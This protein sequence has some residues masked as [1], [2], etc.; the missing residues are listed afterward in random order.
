MQKKL[1]LT[2]DERVYDGL[3]R[4]IGRGSISQFIEALVRPYVID[5]D[6]DAA[7][8]EMAADQAREAEAEEWIEA[9][10]GDGVIELG[11][12]RRQI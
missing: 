10:V 8:R 3:H 7:Y 4:R 11:R 6:L 12:L 5:A 9:L 2:I 1:T